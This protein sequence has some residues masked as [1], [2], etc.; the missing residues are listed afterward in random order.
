MRQTTFFMSIAYEEACKAL[1]KGEVPVGA[2][3]VRGQEILGKAY[4]Q[5]ESLHSPL[6]HAEILAIQEAC[7]KQKD[8]RLEGTHL[9]VTLEPCLMCTSLILESRISKV[10]YGCS[11]P[12]VGVFKNHLKSLQKMSLN[13]HDKLDVIGG[14]ESEK[15]SSLLKEFFKNQR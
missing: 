12:N 8:W 13:H 5:R 2:V 9:Y 4:N 14:V 10:I 15:C 11:D 6:A 7:Q 3:L 1:K